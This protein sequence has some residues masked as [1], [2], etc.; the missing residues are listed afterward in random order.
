VQKA[1]SSA[2][3]C[4]VEMGEEDRSGALGR[5]ALNRPRLHPRLRNLTLIVDVPYFAASTLE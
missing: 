3:F 1:A 5:N 2:V 4:V